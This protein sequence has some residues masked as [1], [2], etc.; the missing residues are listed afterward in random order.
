VP[1]SIL[2][3]QPADLGLGGNHRAFFSSQLKLVDMLV[4]AIGLRSSPEGGPTNAFANPP[5]IMMI[6]VMTSHRLVYP[7]WM[8]RPRQLVFPQQANGSLIEKDCK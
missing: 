8:N 6:F 1:P 2:R 4:T 3:P 5:S 7:L